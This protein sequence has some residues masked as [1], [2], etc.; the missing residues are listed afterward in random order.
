VSRATER[1]FTT[2][3]GVELVA[4]PIRADDREALRSHFEALS[5]E[6]RYRRFLTA[7]KHL[8]ARE[9]TRLTDLDH[10]DQEA[11]VALTPGGELIGVARFFRL[12]GD[13]TRAEVAVTIADAWQ[14]RGVGTALLHLL[15]ERAA[16]LG[17]RCFVATCLAHN[18]P[19]LDLFRELGTAVS[20][21]PAGDGIVEVEV[22]LPT[23]EGRQH[24]SAAL[25]RFTHA[26]A[27]LAEP[28]G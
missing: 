4:R 9:L 10:S 2:L 17:V 21:T 28:R 15:S 24:Y 25:R 12:V 23:G 20:E 26:V 7:I 11:L 13:S 22:E 1:R 16:E 5:A 19:M 8:S 6:T 18:R 14:G 27:H 3:D